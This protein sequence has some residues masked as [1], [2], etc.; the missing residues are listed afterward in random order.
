MFGSKFSK[1]LFGNDIAKVGFGGLDNKR[2]KMIS[3]TNIQPT[4]KAKFVFSRFMFL[5]SLFLS[6]LAFVK[7]NHI[8]VSKLISFGGISGI[9][10][11]LFI[12]DMTSNL[13]GSLS[14]LL[15]QSFIPGD[16]ISF[17]SGGA[18]IQ[19]RV[20]SSG[21]GHT[22]ICSKDTQITHVPNA[23]FLQTAVTNLDSISHRKFETT[24]SIN[25]QV[26]CTL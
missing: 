6:L 21:W 5:S 20:E 15:T 12:K 26:G 13:M 9:L 3:Y 22:Q 4:R 1:K 8:P 14:L 19:G 18:V 17:R 7:L 24:V 23:H 16:S 2:A 11:S 10:V 25:H